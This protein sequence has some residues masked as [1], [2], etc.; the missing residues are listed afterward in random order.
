MKGGKSKRKKNEKTKK[1]SKKIEKENKEVLIEN[2]EETENINENDD[3]IESKNDIKELQNHFKEFTDDYRNKIFQENEDYEEKELEKISIKETFLKGINNK[4]KLPQFEYLKENI[5]QKTIETLNRIE[6][7]IEENEYAFNSSKINQRI[8]EKEILENSEYYKENFIKYSI[9]RLIDKTFIN[10]NLK[11][12]LINK[13]ID[14]PINLIYGGK[15]FYCYTNMKQRLKKY[16]IQLNYFCTKH[17]VKSTNNNNKFICN[18][19]IVYNRKEK[20]FYFIHPHSVECNDI[21]E[22]IPNNIKDIKK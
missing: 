20:N 2:N 9:K 14:W 22:V 18:A 12:S 7:K 6:N 13:E 5:E 17:R 11:T 3:A 15:K 1:V 4:V 8:A 10:Y 21:S 16:K 19:K